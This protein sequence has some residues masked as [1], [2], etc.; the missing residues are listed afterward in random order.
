MIAGGPIGRTAWQPAPSALC[1]YRASSTRIARTSHMSP[2]G[3]TFLF[4]AKGEQPR[5]CSRMRR[6]AVGLRCS[7]TRSEGMPGACWTTSPYRSLSASRSGTGSTTAGRQGGRGL[8]L[9]EPVEDCPVLWAR[10]PHTP[11]ISSDGNAGRCRRGRNGRFHR[12]R[13]ARGPL[14]SLCLRDRREAVDAGTGLFPGSIRGSVAAIHPPGGAS[15]APVPRPGIRL[16][17]HSGDASHRPGPCRCSFS[18]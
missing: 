14:S 8:R 5:I 13:T 1:W 17:L 12:R 7:P 6:P 10:L 9:C 15:L 18:T 4:L 2:S 11:A 3:V 16:T